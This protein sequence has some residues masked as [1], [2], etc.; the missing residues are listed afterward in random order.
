MQQHT[1]LSVVPDWTLFN[2]AVYY[3]SGLPIVKKSSQ[4]DQTSSICFETFGPECNNDVGN[5]ENDDVF[6]DVKVVSV[7]GETPIHYG[8]PMVPAT[9]MIL[10]ADTGEVNANLSVT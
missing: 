5:N 1:A 6:M 4:E 10:N 7:G 9:I 2:P 8:K 3:P